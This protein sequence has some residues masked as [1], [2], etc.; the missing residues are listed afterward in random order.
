MLFRS[1][2]KVSY[3]YGHI[4][5]SVSLNVEQIIEVSS[6]GAHFAPNTQKASS[7]LGELGIDNEKPLVVCGELMDPSVFR[8]AWTL[9]YLG[10][11]NTKILNRSIS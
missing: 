2:P 3:S 5:N 1:R 9:Q 8:V 6:T 11:K 4:P 10:Q 7:Q